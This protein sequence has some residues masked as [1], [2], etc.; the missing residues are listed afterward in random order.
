MKFFLLTIVA[1]AICFTCHSQL[2]KQ[3]YP[4][5]INPVK[6]RNTIV[7]ESG[8]YIS[9]LSF[10][11]FI[12]YA[13]KQRVPFHYYDDSRGYLQMDKA[14]HAYG[15]Y[16]FSY[17][18]YYAL[19][20]AGVD[21][22]R[23]LLFGGPMGLIFQTPIEIFD[24]LYE[25]WG[26]SWP[27]MAANA[28][29]SALFTAQEIVFDKQAILMKFSYYP[30]PYA[31]MH[32]HLGDSH[33]ERFFLDYNAHTYWLSGNIKTLTSIQRV[34]DWLNIALGYS[35][36]GMI[37]EFHNPDYY[38]GEPFPDLDRHRQYLLSLDIDFTQISVKRKWLKTVLRAANLI[39][40]PFP[41]LEWNEV[42]GLRF[43]P[44]YF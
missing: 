36:N 15:A 26:F 39:K 42:N 38:Q 30:S 20:Q 22:K 16:F 13:D 24:G 23:S 34:P 40:I 28:L 31:D 12:W 4:D 9:G 8:V 3:S 35:A 17:S 19:R 21:K 44:L 1:H 10:L 2:F 14:G 32:S 33:A 6:L 18:T 25:G 7:A 37:F 41:A 5:S 11:S 27:D 29:G 43:R